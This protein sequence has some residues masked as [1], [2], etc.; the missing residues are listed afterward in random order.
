MAVVA[1]RPGA[2]DFAEVTA[3]DVAVGVEQVMD[4]IA[5]HA[6]QRG[7]ES[8]QLGHRSD[9]VCCLQDVVDRIV[10]QLAGRDDV[11]IGVG[12]KADQG[13]AADHLAGYHKGYQPPRTGSRS[14]VR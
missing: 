9:R 8:V 12:D 4:G 2:A 10:E 13:S 7:Q 14:F 3:V 1:A 11:T 6:G 5:V